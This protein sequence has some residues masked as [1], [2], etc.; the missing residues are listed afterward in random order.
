AR[1]QAHGIRVHGSTIIGLEHH[2]PIPGTPLYREEQA[3]GYSTTSTR[4]DF[5]V[6]GPG[7]YRLMHGMFT[8]WRPYRDDEDARVRQRVRPRPR[9]W[10]RV[11]AQHSGPGRR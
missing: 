5:D 2:T 9:V 4:R 11:T 8:S 6:N 7:R 3:D 1:S 10:P